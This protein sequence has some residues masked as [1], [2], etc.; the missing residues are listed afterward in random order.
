VIKGATNFT[1]ADKA[2]CFE[3][4]RPHAQ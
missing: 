1:G 3:D 2:L 4:L